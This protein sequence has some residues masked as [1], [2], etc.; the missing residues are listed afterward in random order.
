MFGINVGR[1]KSLELF[2]MKT[3]QSLF[4]Y[5]FSWDKHVQYIKVPDEWGDPIP[6]CFWSVFDL[7]KIINE[8]LAEQETVGMMLRMTTTFPKFHW[9]LWPKKIGWDS[10]IFGYIYTAITQ[11]VFIAYF[12]IVAEYTQ[13]HLWI[14][15]IFW[16]NPLCKYWL[17]EL[18][19]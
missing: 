5:L 14:L 10:K 6:C 18:F 15:K 4:Q 12:I 13:N 17:I 9:A 2:L 1:K 16:A 19:I 7:C 3:R 11:K 8:R